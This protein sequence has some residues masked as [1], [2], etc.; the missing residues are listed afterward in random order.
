HLLHERQQSFLDGLR[1]DHHRQRELLKRDRRRRR[2]ALLLPDLLC[3]SLL[4]GGSLV[5]VD[6]VWR[7]DH[8]A[9][10]EPPLLHDFNRGRG[11]PPNSKSHTS[12]TS[13]TR[14]LAC[15]RRSWSCSSWLGFVRPSRSRRTREMA[16][17]HFPW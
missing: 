13:T 9:T 6:R 3:G 14:R 5:L 16:G 8:R 15:T 4:H 11:I 2:H 12:R 17:P 1:R 10:L 7:P